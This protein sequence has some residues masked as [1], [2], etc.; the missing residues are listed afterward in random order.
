MSSNRKSRAGMDRRV[1]VLGAS[2]LAL[3]PAVVVSCGTALTTSHARLLRRFSET[4]CVNFDQ[5]EAGQRAARKS[6]E[7]LLGEGLRVR[8]VELPE[9]HD[10]DS[11][12]R[13]E[14]G[15]AYR[16]RLEEAPEALE[17]LM[18]R[19]EEANDVSSPEGKARFLGA[20]LPV[21]IR[22]ETRAG[23]GAG[24]AGI[25]EDYRDHWRRIIEWYDTHFQKAIEEEGG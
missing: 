18:R 14:G 20:L 16:R 2:A 19:A 17:W 3:G 25:E 7:V 22:V 4:V 13:A 9:G 11:F 21:L 24:R 5:D 23:H 8:V 6:L 10:P 15:D 1:Q 12:L